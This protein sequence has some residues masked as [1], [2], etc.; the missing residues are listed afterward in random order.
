MSESNYENLFGTPEW[1]AWTLAR[2]R[3]ISD[4]SCT[5]YPMFKSNLEHCKSDYTRLK[6]IVEWLRGDAE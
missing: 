4:G 3:A 2:M 1:A 5:V 6:S